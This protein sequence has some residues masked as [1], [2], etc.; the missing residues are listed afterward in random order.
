MIGDHHSVKNCIKGSQHYEPLVYTLQ[1]NK[2]Q[3]KKKTQK[4]PVSSMYVCMCVCMY[5]S[6]CVYACVCVCV[7]VCVYI[8]ISKSL[9]E[10]SSK[11]GQIGIRV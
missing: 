2:T 7:C 1:M 10:K 6:V 5:I 4:N 11:Q 8:N 9:K 3:K